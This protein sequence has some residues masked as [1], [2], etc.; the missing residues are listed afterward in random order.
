MQRLH[1]NLPFS[2][3][4]AKRALSISLAMLVLG[5]YPAKLA[6]FAR[7]F[8]CRSVKMPA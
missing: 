4:Q 8:H 3:P 5:H 7:D 2:V 1:D 6:P